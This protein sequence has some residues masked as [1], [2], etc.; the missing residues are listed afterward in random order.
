M[1]KWISG[2]FG[3]AEGFGI[4][5]AFAGT[6]IGVGFLS[7]QEILRFFGAFGWQGLIGIFAAAAAFALFGLLV[8]ATAKRM[9]TSNFEKVIAPPWGVF[10]KALN[11]V[12]T[13]L[14]F[15]V[16]TIML[17]AAGELMES[18]FS[19]PGILGSA[20]M[21]ALSC[22]TVL[23][24]KKGLFSSFCVVVPAMLLASVLTGGWGV[25]AGQEPLFSS[26]SDASLQAAPALWLSTALFISYN[27]MGAVSVLVPLGNEASTRK[28]LLFGSVCGAAFLGLM[29]AAMCAAMLKNHAAVFSASMPMQAVAAALNPALGKVYGALLFLGVF[30]TTAGMTFSMTTRL[31]E[32]RLPAFLTRPVLAVAISVLAAAGSRVGFSSLVGSVYPVY[33]YIGFVVLGCLTANYFY[34]KKKAAQAAQTQTR[35]ESVFTGSTESVFTGSTESVFTGSGDNSSA[36]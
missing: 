25:A 14:L 5:T 18:V 17:A 4:A 22:L 12:M 6:L 1:R 15:G 32:Y 24:G 21:A 16:I 30:T 2:G 31:L 33:G 13:L 3:I 8:M 7:G 11:L 36:E 34:Q 35:M 29:A 10:P 28:E 20:L 9:G 27:I 26:F 19:L 23:F